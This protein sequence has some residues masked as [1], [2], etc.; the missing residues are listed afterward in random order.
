MHR[1]SKEEY[2]DRFPKVFKTITSDNGSEYSDLS[3]KLKG[4]GIKTY[5]TMGA[6]FKRV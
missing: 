5:F 2:E 6:R 3:E 1:I 4:Y